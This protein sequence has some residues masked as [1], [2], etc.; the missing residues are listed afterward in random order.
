MNWLKRTL[1]S[2]LGA[3][4]LM[5]ITGFMLFGFLIAHLSGNL[6]AYAGQD[7]F[8]TYAAK[9]KSLGPLLWVA[10]LGLLAV[11]VSHV[12]FAARLT[13]ANRAARPIAYAK[14]ATI[15]ASF[16]SRTMPYTGLTVLLFIGYHLAHYTLHLIDPSFAQMHDSLGRHDA[17]GML[18]VGFQQPLVVGL[19]VA[20]MLAIGVHLQ[21]GL[22]S[23]FQ[24][25]GLSHPNMNGL[26]RSAAPAIAWLIV[27]LFLS[28]PVSV[29]TGIIAEVPA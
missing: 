29:L 23:L 18:V 11:A 9:L 7:A 4:Y 20:G 12:V 17:Y 19:Y 8:N 14:Q 27:L 5:A 25:L 3:K 13:A 16:A 1:C 6:L 2:S 28:I 24:S 15:Q 10:R 21:H 26:I 22:S